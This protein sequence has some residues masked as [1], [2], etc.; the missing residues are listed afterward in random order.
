MYLGRPHG[1][2]VS[3]AVSGEIIPRE[4]PRMV[5]SP[6]GCPIYCCSIL[7]AR[8]KV[9]SDITFPPPPAVSGYHQQQIRLS[10]DTEISHLSWIGDPGWLGAQVAPALAL[11]EA[12]PLGVSPLPLG[13]CSMGAAEP[14]GLY[15]VSPRS[16]WTSGS[17]WWLPPSVGSSS[18]TSPG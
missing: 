15:G 12:T 18:S 8:A 16:S 17:G 3:P 9:Y 10:P 13:S 2:S 11:E 6:L 1:L 5:H 4:G 14:S 7:R